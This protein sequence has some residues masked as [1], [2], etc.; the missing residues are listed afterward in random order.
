LYNLII[1]CRL[2]IIILSNYSVIL[3]KTCGKCNVLRST[4]PLTG[5][6]LWC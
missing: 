3:Y 6:L 2:A 1:R 4:K 5:W